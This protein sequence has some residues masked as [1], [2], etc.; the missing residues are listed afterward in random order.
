MNRK[1]QNS[2]SKQ[3]VFKVAKKL[4]FAGAFY[5]LI[6]TITASV[7]AQTN[8]LVPN[9]A[10]SN[11]AVAAEEFRRGVQSFNRAQFNEAI[12][13][14]EKALA[15]LPDEPVILDW[16]G[17]SYFRSG[18]EGEAL[19]H[20]RR[21]YSQDYGGSLLRSRIETIEERRTTV[22]DTIYDYTYAEQV[23][24][25]SKDNANEFFVQPT[26][27]LA[28]PDGSFWLCAYGSNELVHFDING[29]ILNKTRGPMQGFARPFDIIQK[30]D[31]SLL[32]S[33]FAGDRISVLTPS[34]S[35]QT[36]FG[37]KGIGD[38]QFV[39][40][41]YLALDSFEN[42]YITDFGCARI[43]VFSPD[44]DFLFTFGERSA[45][46]EGFIAPS[47]IA[48]FE[49]IVYVSDSYYGCVYMF[50]TAGN[51][52]GE[53]LPHNGLKN[54]QGLKVW[55][56]GLLILDRKSAYR[57]DIGTATLTELVSLGNAP[58]RLLACTSDVN[59]NL[60]LVDYKNQ[61]LKIA[62]TIKELA[63]GMFVTVQKIISERYPLVELEV[64]VENRDGK[65]IVGLKD[66]NFYVTEK[67]TPVSQ[68]QFDGAASLNTDCD[69]AIVIERS[70][71]GFADEAIIKNA[72]AEIV[73]AVGGNGSVRIIAASEN[74]SLETLSGADLHFK[75]PVS[76]QWKLDKAIRL[77]SNSLLNA[78]PKRAV[79]YLASGGNLSAGFKDYGL[80]DLASFMNNNGIQF[81][82]INLHPIAVSEEAQYLVYKTGGSISYVYQSSGLAPVVRGIAEA[83][84]GLYR[85][86]YR[87]TLFSNFGRDFLPVEVEVR[88]MTR[89]GRDE[90]QY[91]AP[92][93]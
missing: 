70:M 54:A 78:G 13:S 74:P 52:L 73:E 58:A 35:Y 71:E 17:K 66:K 80:N 43:V 81:Y 38:G 49:D 53:L 50:D 61:E 1:N 47:G 24:L 32:V 79:I 57:L 62:S 76:A 36:S 23:A 15:Y 83:P 5:T 16:L 33:E 67:N 45:S 9:V 48:V 88:L 64:L 92:L 26:S 56:N 19:E 90:I 31:G 91:F 34:G 39:G 8:S 63:G 10:Q 51:Y 18:L 21:A 89:S 41:Q 7:F 46:F 59:S 77:A 60:L 75:S 6:A 93:E 40:P 44:G 69:I 82:T 72:C 20:W 27:V 14:F 3:R 11:S 85:M 65:P 86:S 4:F 87:S 22:S 2:Y 29:I 25:K 42:I 55:Q 28:L 37:S 30:R 84:S 68:F 12:M